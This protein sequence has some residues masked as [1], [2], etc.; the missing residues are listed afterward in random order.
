MVIYQF[1]GLDSLLKSGLFLYVLAANSKARAVRKTPALNSGVEVR[2]CIQQKSERDPRH[3]WV[4]LGF[5]AVLAATEL[6]VALLPKL[7]LPTS[8][9]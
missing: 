8:P 1:I 5:L 6:W 9:S 7:W 4:G 3:P 2:F